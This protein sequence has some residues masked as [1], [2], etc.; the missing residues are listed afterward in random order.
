[1]PDKSRAGRSIRALRNIRAA[2]PARSHRPARGERRGWGAGDR[3]RCRVLATFSGR[4]EHET[5]P[6]DFACFPFPS[7]CRDEP[8]ARRVQM[9]RHGPHRGARLAPCF[10]NRSSTMRVGPTTVTSS[11]TSRRRTSW[12]SLVLAAFFAWLAGSAC[13]AERKTDESPPVYG[14]NVAPILAR[15][16]ASCHAP[17]SPAGGW[18]AAS[19]LDA[20]A[21]VGSSGAAATLPSDG[22]APIVRALDSATHQ[23]VVDATERSVFEAWVRAGA[24]AFRGTVHTAGIVD[25]R[26]PDWHGKKLRDERWAPMLD[27]NH[28][29]ACGRC[30]DG[31][32]ARPT[33][34]TGAAPSAPACTTCHAEPEGVLACNTCHGD[35]M[36]TYPPRDPC[37]FPSDAATSGAHRAHVETSPLRATALACATCHPVPS[38]DVISG[39]H[40]NGSTEIVFDKA[41]VSAEASYDRATGQCAVSCHDR[42]GAR[43][44]PMWT[45]ANAMT[46][47]DCHASPPVGHFPGACSTC[48]RE[49]N[50]TGT[51]LV[52]NALHMNGRVDPGDASGGCGACHGH[53]DDPWPMRAAHSSH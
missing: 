53:R 48:H 38:S 50:A 46:C 47:G 10:A 41:I 16:C 11:L 22:T 9:L 40:G 39:V 45:D 13:I 29:E 24:P 30:H 4:N 37:F 44:R 8:V 20:I 7:A 23:G 33:G 51:A 35:K 1:M 49:A 12:S 42:G 32:P 14:E 3:R 21:C 5:C 26:S 28:S 15:R 31:T 27:P 6:F 43:A 18:S 25:P 2:L 36:R 17:P 34:V 52:A 19:Y